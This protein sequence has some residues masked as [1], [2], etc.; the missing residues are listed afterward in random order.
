MGIHDEV[1]ARH[2]A[3]KAVSPNTVI[4]VKC[5]AYYEFIGTDAKIVADLTNRVLQRNYANT[6][7]DLCGVPVWNGTELADA[8]ARNGHKLLLAE[9]S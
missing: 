8:M 1:I 4:G 2:A 9:L 5:G 7:Q 6:G 3:L